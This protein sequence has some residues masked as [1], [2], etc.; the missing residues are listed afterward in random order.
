MRAAARG[1]PPAQLLYSFSNLLYG[2]SVSP[3]RPAH[4]TW[5]QNE[6]RQSHAGSNSAPHFPEMLWRKR[7]PNVDRISLRTNWGN[8]SRIFCSRWCFINNECSVT[9]CA[10]KQ[11]S[12]SLSYT[13]SMELFV[14]MG[15]ENNCPPY[16]FCN[17]SYGLL[18]AAY[19][20]VCV[21][22]LERPHVTGRHLCWC[23]WLFSIVQSISLLFRRPSVICFM[24]TLISYV[25]LTKPREQQTGS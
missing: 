25:L 22:R 13:R 12:A 2:W 5:R 1:R 7:L 11:P 10:A 8:P 3:I 15:S 6:N 24:I 4:T 21:T 16:Q 20:C 17:S 19:Y 23:L 9:A 14:S 18:L